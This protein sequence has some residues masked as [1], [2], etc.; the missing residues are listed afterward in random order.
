MEPGVEI[1]IKKPRWKKSVTGYFVKIEKG[2]IRVA[3][4]PGG[5]VAYSVREK[6]VIQRKTLESSQGEI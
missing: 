2:W 6:D 5:P 1:K 4:K 3:E